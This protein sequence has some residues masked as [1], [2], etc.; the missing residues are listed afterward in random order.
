MM[1]AVEAIGEMTAVGTTIGAEAMMTV[2]EEDTKGVMT[3]VTIGV[4]GATAA[5]IVRTF[6]YTVLCLT[7]RVLR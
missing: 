5:A 3:G 2:V 6:F 1:T 4:E 7:S